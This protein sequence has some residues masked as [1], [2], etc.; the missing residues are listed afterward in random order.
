MHQG[1]KPKKSSKLA[2]FESQQDST[3]GQISRQPLCDKGLSAPQKNI[4][5]PF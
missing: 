4:D 3:Q 5:L 1:L 2:D